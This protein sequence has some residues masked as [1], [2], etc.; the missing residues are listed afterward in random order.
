MRKTR[1][2]MRW[3]RTLVAAGLLVA[4]G[5]LCAV[6]VAVAGSGGRI[7]TQLAPTATGA[8][9]TSFVPTSAPSPGARTTTYPDASL[10]NPA[11]GTPIPK[12]LAAQI[13]AQ[14]ATDQ[15]GAKGH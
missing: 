10:S 9:G 14:Q 12:G 13:A 4:T 5:V 1:M 3:V 8:S 11:P 6:G 15:A 2:R 7:S